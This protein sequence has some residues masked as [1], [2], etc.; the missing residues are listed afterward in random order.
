MKNKPS[1]RKEKIKF[2][3]ELQAGYTTVSEMIYEQITIWIIQDDEYKNLS[4][5]KVYTKEEYVKIIKHS[6]SIHLHPSPGCKPLNI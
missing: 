1:T 2:L 4:T 5:G 3:N 6:K